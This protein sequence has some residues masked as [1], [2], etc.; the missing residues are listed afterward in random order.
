MYVCAC[1]LHASACVFMCMCRY[2]MCIWRP[3][4]DTSCFLPAL[5]TYVLTPDLSLEHEL[6]ELSGIAEHVAL[7]PLVLPP[8]HWA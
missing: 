8:E 2:A 5:L 1:G 3:D 4:V 7:G 6:A